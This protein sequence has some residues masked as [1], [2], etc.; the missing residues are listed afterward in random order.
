MNVRFVSDELEDA[1]DGKVL[2]L[3]DKQ[4]LDPVVGDIRFAS[5][6]NILEEVNGHVICRKEMVK[7]DIF[8]NLPYG[9]RYTSK[10]P[11]RKL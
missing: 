3:R 4:G 9:G 11:A 5:S 2:V 10:S 8:R 6:Q 1:V 7:Q